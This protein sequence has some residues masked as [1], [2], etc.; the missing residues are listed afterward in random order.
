VGELVDDPGQRAAGLVGEGADAVEGVLADGDAVGG[1]VG[2]CREVALGVLAHDQ[3]GVV[4]P[5]RGGVAPGVNDPARVAQ[6]VVHERGDMTQRVGDS[7][8]LDRGHPAVAEVVP[9]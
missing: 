2:P 9:K 5:I 8:G 3:A 6:A 7:R 4:V 1:V